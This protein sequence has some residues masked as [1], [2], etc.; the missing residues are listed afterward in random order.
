[1]GVWGLQ[2]RLRTDMG[3]W[4]NW[5]SGLPWGYGA[6]YNKGQEQ[7]WVTRLTGGQDCHGGMGLTTQG[8]NRYG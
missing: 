4:V 3:D 1:M 5:G 2:P 7:T 8:K 6:Y